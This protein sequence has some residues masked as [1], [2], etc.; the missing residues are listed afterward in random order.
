KPGDLIMPDQLIDRTRARASSFF[1]GG[2]VAHVIF[3]NPFCPRL[4]QALLRTAL[5]IAPSVHQGGTYVVIEGPAFSTRAESNLYRS[6]G[7]SIIGMT[8]LPE[9]KLAREAEICYAM[10]AG[11]T[12][13]DC[14]QE[15]C[16][17]SPV[18]EIINTQHRIT[19]QIK[20]ILMLAAG[21]VTS[22]RKCDCASAL[23]TAIVTNPAVIPPGQKQKLGL[24]IDK[25]LT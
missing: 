2:V 25:Y 17:P 4:S 7:A 6:W 20:D 22:Q 8:A 19:Q 5:E 9:A 18:D 3:A 23:K 13:Y 14:W 21:R 16:E 11:V 15:S 12:D 10:L 24:L 1:E